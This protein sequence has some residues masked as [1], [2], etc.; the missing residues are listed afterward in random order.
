MCFET[1]PPDVSPERE[2]PSR[3]RSSPRSSSA[4][5]VRADDDDVDDD[6]ACDAMRRARPRSN[7]RDFLGG[8][9]KREQGNFELRVIID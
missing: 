9:K 8:V 1:Y 2:L 7:N 4:D 3:A 6:G 5:F